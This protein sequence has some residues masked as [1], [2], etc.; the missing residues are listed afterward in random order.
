M[1]VMRQCSVWVALVALAVTAGG[2]GC[3]LRPPQMVRVPAGSFSMGD[4]W[5]EGGTDEQPVHD[6]TL[7]AYEIGTCEVTNAQYAAVLNW[8][9]GEGYIAGVDNGTVTYNGQLLI[10]LDAAAG[11]ITCAGD[12]FATGA[13]D[14]HDM[15]DHPVVGVSWYGAVAYCAWL[16]EAWRQP[17]C[18]DLATWSLTDPHAGGYRLP[19]EAEWERA[20]AWDGERHWRYATTRDTLST[21]Q[22]NVSLSNPAGLPDYPYTAPVGS[23]D[24]QTSPV[25]CYDMSGNVWEWTHDRYGSLYYGTCTG[26]V[27]DPLGPTDA[28]NR[29]IRGGAWGAILEDCRTA[30]RRSWDPDFS[31]VVS[32]SIGFRIAR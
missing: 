10:D 15:A 19:T 3:D 2:C 13:L 24:D 1:S 32:Y 12:A 27:T 22:A 8:A 28:P 11:R 4:P 20:A 31:S 14:G 25:G 5:D 17:A 26:G 30:N 7:S 9:R 6:V 18:Y 29:V 23:F 21:S 16:S